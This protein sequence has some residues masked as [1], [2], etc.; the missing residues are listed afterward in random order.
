MLFM[1]V[2]GR[3]PSPGLERLVRPVE[4]FVLVISDSGIFVSLSRMFI[5][6]AGVDARIIHIGYHAV[7]S[8]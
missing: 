7:Q 8:G 3:S 1:T 2:I 4:L 6:D 5:L